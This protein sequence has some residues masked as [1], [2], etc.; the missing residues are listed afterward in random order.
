MAAV[1]T[2][3]PPRTRTESSLSRTEARGAALG[4]AL[5]AIG[6][7]LLP[8]FRTAVMAIMGEED[9]DYPRPADIRGEDWW[10]V[11]GAV[12]FTMIGIGVLLMATSLRRGHTAGARLGTAL[13]VAGGAGFLLA[14][15]GARTMY[16]FIA[17]NLTGTGADAGAQVAALWAVNIVSGA[18]LVFAGCATAGWLLWL[19]IAGVRAGLLGRPAAIVALVG[20]ILIPIG[21]VGV[22]ILGVQ[23]AFVPVFVVLAISFWRQTRRLR[24]TAPDA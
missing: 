17:A 12:I 15:A 22:V 23:F 1:E 21:E 11:S 20:G 18:F 4:A 2:P 6:Y 5:G 14:G 8:T 3:L 13:G 9:V 10:G 24:Q 16:S 7:I 19:G